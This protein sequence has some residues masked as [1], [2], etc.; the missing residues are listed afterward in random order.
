MSPKMR[1]RTRISAGHRSRTWS[2]MSASS[3]QARPRKPRRAAQAATL[4]V[5]HGR[6]ITSLLRR[7]RAQIIIIITGRISV[8]CGGRCGADTVRIR[9]VIAPC[10]AGGC[11]RP[12]VYSL[13]VPAGGDGH[14]SASR[15][16]PQASRR[17]N[18]PPTIRPA[19]L[20][21]PLGRL[22]D[23]HSVVQR[24]KRVTAILNCGSYAF[25]LC[26]ISVTSSWGGAAAALVR[27]SA[28]SYPGDHSGRAPTVG[29]V[30]GRC[31][32]SM[33]MSMSMSVSMSVQLSAGRC[34]LQETP[35]DSRLLGT[36]DSRRF[37]ETAPDG[38]T[39]DSGDA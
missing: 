35:G 38:D 27:S 16:S 33:S 10:G 20:S 12:P 30:V 11:R 7:P 34:Q 25:F 32:L 26:S 19:P 14:P 23:V 3:P 8:T 1:Y 9:A 31:E 17:L 5:V 21:L 29:A 2:R 39:R 18:V 15:T 28:R 6:H 37:Q 36:P 13:D 4:G 22:P 24:Q